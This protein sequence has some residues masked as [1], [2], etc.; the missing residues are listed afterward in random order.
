MSQQ[1]DYPR[2]LL[3][4]GKLESVVSVF[5]NDGEYKLSVA[6]EQEHHE[7]THIGQGSFEV[8]ADPNQFNYVHLHRMDNIHWRLNEMN[9]GLVT[10][11]DCEDITQLAEQVLATRNEAVLSLRYELDAAI[12]QRDNLST[13]LLELTWELRKSRSERDQLEKEHTDLEE[14]AQRLRDR[15][16]EFEDL[17]LA[18]ER[19]VLPQI[20]KAN[21]ALIALC[22]VHSNLRGYRVPVD[23]EMVVGC[24]MAQRE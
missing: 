12:S 2:Y 7:I 19:G 18:E 8:L 15:V 5:K 14:A 23:G 20:L 4:H 17:Q 22:R 3:C 16:N 9:R 21:Q 1:I 10:S 13:E 11:T 6:G 24:S